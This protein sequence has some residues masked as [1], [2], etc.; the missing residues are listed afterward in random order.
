M[1]PTKKVKA[2]KPLGN[3]VK[4]QKLKPRTRIE[5]IDKYLKS[6]MNATK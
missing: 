2:F 1:K 5:K 4:V 6:A 3:R